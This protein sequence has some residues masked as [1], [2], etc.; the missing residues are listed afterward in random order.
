ML[1]ATRAW[2]AGWMAKECGQCLG[3][4]FDEEAIQTALQNYD[5]QSIAFR[6]KDF[7]E[8]EPQKAWDAAVNFDVIEHIYPEH[9]AEFLQKIASCLTPEGVAVI[10]TPSLISDQFANPHTK[11]GH[12]NLYSHERLESELKEHFEFVFLFSAND[13]LVHTGFSP[14]AHYYIALCCKPKR[15][16]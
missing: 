7:L 4:D 1:A 6:C 8:F 12:V 13:E 5:D 10:G 9:A 14:L 16:R 11:A 3:L 2:V 15:A